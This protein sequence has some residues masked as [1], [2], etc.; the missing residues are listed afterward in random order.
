M[1]CE[2]IE[3]IRKVKVSGRWI[4]ETVQAIKFE[5]FAI[6]HDVGK[7]YI[8]LHAITGRSVG[9]HYL[10]NQCLQYLKH[11]RNFHDWEYVR[12]TI[13]R[14]SELFERMQNAARIYGVS[15]L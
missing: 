8:M 13:P 5:Q 3:T 7:K 6:Y 15:G 2:K 10:F 12:E 4:N 9:E 1:V 11:I 14:E